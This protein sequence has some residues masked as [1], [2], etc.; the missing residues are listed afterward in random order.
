MIVAITKLRK[1]PES[2]NLCKGLESDEN[3]VLQI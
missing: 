2:C 1:L 3:G